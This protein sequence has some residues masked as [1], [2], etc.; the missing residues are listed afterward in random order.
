MVPPVDPDTAWGSVCQHGNFGASAV[1]EVVLSTGLSAGNGEDSGGVLHIVRLKFKASQSHVFLLNP[2]CDK[3]L[4][5]EVSCPWPSGFRIDVSR[6]AGSTSGFRGLGCHLTLRP[7]CS[8][9][10]GR[11]RIMNFDFHLIILMNLGRAPP[12]EHLVR[13]EVL[14]EFMK[15]HCLGPAARSPLASTTQ[16]RHGA[17]DRSELRR[18]APGPESKP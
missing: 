11:R 10:G 9:L 14:I 7:I 2:S 4:E 5:L 13:P 12:R 17:L 6:N 8:V 15:V 16:S 18:W 1:L 3:A